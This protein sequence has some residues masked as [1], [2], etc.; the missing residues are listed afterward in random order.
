[1]KNRILFAAIAVSMLSTAAP[2]L[3]D[4]PNDPDM[5]TRAAREADA[6][7][8]RQLNLEQA[9][10]VRER[11]ARLY[12]ENRAYREQPAREA[13]YRRDLDRY[14]RSRSEYEAELEAWRRAVR[15][16]RDGYYEYCR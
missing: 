10:Y 2:A 5:Q 11:D 4:D 7:I 9:A 6:A 15:L 13:E 12:E 14:E 8:I 16:C 1:M 3:A